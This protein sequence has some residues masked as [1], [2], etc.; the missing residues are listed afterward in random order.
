MNLQPALSFG[1]ITKLKAI[2]MAKR[3]GQ[4][5]VALNSFNLVAWSTANNQ[6]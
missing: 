2:T 4:A 5:L 6:G 3:S 1:S